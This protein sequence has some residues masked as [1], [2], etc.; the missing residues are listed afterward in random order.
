[1]SRRRQP[2][3]VLGGSITRTQDDYR[4]I[5]QYS[6]VYPTPMTVKQIYSN[7]K[8]RR[9]PPK[10]DGTEPEAALK[11]YLTDPI[12]VYTACCGVSLGPFV[13]YWAR[14]EYGLFRDEAVQRHPLGNFPAD[15]FANQPNDAFEPR[16]PT[17]EINGEVGGHA[18]RAFANF[19][20]PKCGREF[21]PRNLRKL[22]KEL[23]EGRPKRYPLMPP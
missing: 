11:I 21:N 15:Y 13:A 8:Q 22:G 10:W 9:Y 1:M 16:N 23:F 5:P 19:R 20:C 12:R 18:A 17:F 3:T 6:P 14:A 7:A 2:V 4:V